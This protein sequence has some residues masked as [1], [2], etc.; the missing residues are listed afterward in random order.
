MH[1]DKFKSF[2]NTTGIWLTQA[3]FQDLLNE[4]IDCKK[5]MQ[6]ILE[7]KSGNRHVLVNEAK[8]LIKKYTGKEI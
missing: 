7:M 6:L 3:E 5:T 8:E 4:H 1:Q 2:I